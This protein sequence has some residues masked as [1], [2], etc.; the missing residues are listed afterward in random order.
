MSRSTRKKPSPPSTGETRSSGRVTR[1]AVQRGLE[2]RQAEDVSD[3]QRLLSDAQYRADVMSRVTDWLGKDAK[4]GDVVGLVKQIPMELLRDEDPK[5]EAKKK[6]HEL[7]EDATKGLQTLVEEIVLSSHFEAKCEDEGARVLERTKLLKLLPDEQIDSMIE[8][9]QMPLKGKGKRRQ[10]A[11][12]VTSSTKP[13]PKLRS[14]MFPTAKYLSELYN[15]EE[16][17]KTEFTRLI[18]G[19]CIVDL[20]VGFNGYN[21]SSEEAPLC[22]RAIVFARLFDWKVADLTT[23]EQQVKTPKQ[24]ADLFWHHVKGV[25]DVQTRDRLRGRLCWSI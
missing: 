8:R 24:R 14:F 15:D 7:I 9:L 23:D 3:A 10:L 21:F 12:S 2:L 25:E 1:G 19:L 11:E 5:R 20:L 16:R 18:D 4:L 22:F 17:L 13:K 6:L